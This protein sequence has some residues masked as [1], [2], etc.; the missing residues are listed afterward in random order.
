MRRSGL[1]DW[2]RNFVVPGAASICYQ[3]ADCL[4]RINRTPAPKAYQAIVLTFKKSTH[5]LIDGIRSWIRDSTGENFARDPGLDNLI[6][7]LFCKA[8]TREKSVRH[9]QWM[10]AFQAG[11]NKCHL[12]KS[13]R[14]NF[15]ERWDLNFRHHI[16]SAL[17]SESRTQRPRS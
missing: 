4:G 2:V 10:A 14:P 3:E 16:L 15:H 17:K 1:G 9:N 5:S 11:K 7:Q 8:A 6:P 13:P 12:G